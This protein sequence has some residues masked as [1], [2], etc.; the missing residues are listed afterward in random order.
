MRPLKLSSPSRATGEGRVF[1]PALSALLLNERPLTLASALGKDCL[2]NVAALLGTP[3]EEQLEKDLYPLAT[4]A[5][6]A[7]I[8]V[9]QRTP[10]ARLNAEALFGERSGFELPPRVHLPLACEPEVFALVR[11]EGDPSFTAEVK[12]FPPETINEALAYALAT[13]SASRMRE[14]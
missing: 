2:A 14:A 1:R 3:K 8:D 10:G 7:C 13:N 12:R 9:R 4:H 11:K 6:P 5:V